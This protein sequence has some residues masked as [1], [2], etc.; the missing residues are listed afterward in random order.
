M[1]SNFIPS[2]KVN[3]SPND[4]NII[5][6]IFFAFHYGFFHVVY[7]IFILAFSASLTSFSSNS[8]LFLFDPLFLISLIILFIN[9]AFSEKYNSGDYLEKSAHEIMFSSYARIVPMHLTLVFG[10]MLVFIFNN[11][12]AMLVLFLILKTIF[13]IKGH[14]AKHKNNF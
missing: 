1:N 11:H 6:A 2:N 13:D 8:V 12:I 5:L 7:F 14:I 9:H 4:F 10:T 3:I